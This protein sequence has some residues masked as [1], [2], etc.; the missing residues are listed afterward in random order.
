MRRMEDRPVAARVGR[1]GLV[2]PVD[3][4][5]VLAPAHVDPVDPVDRVG[6]ADRVGLVDPAGLVGH[7]A[8]LAPV[9]T[10][11]DPVGL[12]GHV[13]RADRADLVDP[14][15]H[16]DLVGRVHLHVRALAPAHRNAHRRSAKVLV[17]ALCV[18]E[19]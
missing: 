15:G 11:V 6:L 4:A 1:A 16:V 3:Q 13:G 18:V 7:A 10:H 12:A 17:P 2:D 8:T 19:Q 9:H 5:A 14:A